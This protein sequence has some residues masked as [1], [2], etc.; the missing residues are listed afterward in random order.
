[1]FEGASEVAPERLLAQL[2]DGGRFVGVMGR[3]PMG[4]ATIFRMNGKHATAQPLFDANAPLLPGFV[5]PAEF[6]F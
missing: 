3:A 6:V 2:K 5:K 1:V 4:K